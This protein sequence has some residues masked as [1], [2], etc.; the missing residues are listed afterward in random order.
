MAAPPTTPQKLAAEFLGT[1]FLVFVGA[2]SAAAT[3]VIAAGTKVPFSMAQLGMISFAFML[4]IVGAVYAIGH[5]SGGHINP[6]VTLSLAVSGK[7]PWREVPGYMIA[8]LAGAIAG[9]ASIYLTLGR[10]ATVAAGGGVTAYTPATMGFGRGMVIEAIGTFM[11]VFVIFGVIDHRAVPGWA[12]MGAVFMLKAFGGTV[13]W[14]QLPAYL[15]GE[16][17]G[18][19]LGGLAWVAIGRV[20]EDAAMTSLAPGEPAPSTANPEKVSGATS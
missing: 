11:L 10:L 5:I 8:Q 9:A 3:G 1:A 14:S 2:G 7:F 16:F 15:I 13:L 6:A 17:V 19:A 12:P 20:R 4:V 18:G